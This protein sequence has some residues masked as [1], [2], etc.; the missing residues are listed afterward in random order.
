[1]ISNQDVEI[2]GAIDI[3]GLE[4]HDSTTAFERRAPLLA[5]TGNRHPVITRTLVQTFE[6]A[7]LKI[8]PTDVPLHQLDYEL[9]QYPSTA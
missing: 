6:Y 3:P 9:D 7:G 5:Y 4:R 1:M 8:G 2:G